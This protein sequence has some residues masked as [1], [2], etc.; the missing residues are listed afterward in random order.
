MPRKPMLKMDGAFEE[1]TE[2]GTEQFKKNRVI[3]TPLARIGVKKNTGRKKTYSPLQM[4]NGCNS[5]YK[6]CEK[7]DR[8][9]SIKGMMLHMKMFREQFYT[10]IADPRYTDILEQAKVI[11]CEWIE[12]DIYQTPGQAAGKLAY[13]KNLHGWA[14]KIDTTSVNETTVRS[15]LSVE[16]AKAKI[17][18]LAHLISPDLLEAVAGKYVLNQIAHDD[19]IVV[20]GE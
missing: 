4:K 17:A 20:E 7:N 1:P 14:E 3:R 5:Y 19:A 16:D 12:N 10:Y 9:P 6:W 8:V 11:I 18:S 15:V 2:E 13:A